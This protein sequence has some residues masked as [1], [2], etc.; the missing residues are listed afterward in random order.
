MKENVNARG[1]GKGRGKEN[2]TEIGIETEIG[3]V[4]VKPTE[5]GEGEVGVGM[6]KF[7]SLRSST[8]P[9]FLFDLI[10][11]PYNSTFLFHS[12]TRFICRDS[13][14]SRSLSPTER[15]DREF[16]R[17]KRRER[18]ERDRRERE[19]STVDREAIEAERDSRTVFAINLPIRA[20]ERKLYDFFEKAGK[21]VDVSLILC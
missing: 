20:S 1:K 13:R 15:D 7:P 11:L 18:E 10:P 21:V 3:A 4:T 6:L 2:E 19:L 12:L 8:L 9:N 5:A 14:R 17:D 16:E